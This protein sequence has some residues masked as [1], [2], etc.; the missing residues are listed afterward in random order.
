MK[1][2]IAALAGQKPLVAL[3]LFQLCCTFYFLVDVA[4]DVGDPDYTIASLLPEMAASLGLIVGILFEMRALLGLL[5]HAA[6]MTQS[7]NVASGALADVIEGYF[8]LWALTP[9]ERDVAAFTI[10]G[11]AIGE[12]AAMRGSAEG[13]VKTHLNAIYRKAGVSGRGQLVSLLVEDL[14]SAPLLPRAMPARDRQDAADPAAA[15]DR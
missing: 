4:K 10:K 9:A 7:L 12:I 1:L 8:S 11:F 5:G 2:S 3:I 15:P 6:R 13:T 14:L